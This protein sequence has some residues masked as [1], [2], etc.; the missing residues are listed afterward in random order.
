MVFFP[1]RQLARLRP[2]FDRRAFVR[3]GY[4]VGRP[5]FGDDLERSCRGAS[6]GSN[7]VVPGRRGQDFPSRPRIG[8][9]RRFVPHVP[10]A[11]LDRKRQR[12]TM[13]R[14]RVLVSL[15]SG[16]TDVERLA[17][18]QR[19]AGLRYV[20]TMNLL[21]LEAYYRYLPLCEE[22]AGLP[23]GKSVDG[24][25]TSNRL[26]RASLC[27][28]IGYIIGRTYWEMGSSRPFFA[29]RCFDVA[30]DIDSFCT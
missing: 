4:A 23:R 5:C 6:V 22:T 14:D 28:A 16:Q 25:Q 29:R 24:T 2:E 15:P 18:R 9:P 8:E 21:S 27:A 11:D 3:E 30:R 13:D 19:I 12:A 10:L 7:R 17:E 20:T 26:C 1:V